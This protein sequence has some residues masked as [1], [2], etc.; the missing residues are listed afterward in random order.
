MTNVIGTIINDCADGSARTRQELRFNTLFGVRPTFLGVGSYSPI[1]AAGNLLDQLDVLTKFPLADKGR[2]NIVLVNVAPRA[3]DV[4]LKWD[5]GTPFCYFRI[6]NTLIVSTYEGHCLALARDLG[7]ISEVQ[8]LDVPTV[9]KAAVEWGGLSVEEAEKVNHSQ[10]RSL[11][12][13][14]LVAYWLWKGKPV[15]SK[16]QSLAE[17]PS[18]K[19]Q[20]WQIDNFD[21]VKTTLLPEDI[22]F[23]QSKQILLHNGE[24]ATCYRR[25]TDVPKYTT[26]LTIGSSGYG[27]RRFLEVVIGGC[28][29][30]GSQ[31]G[32]T[33]GSTVLK[34]IKVREE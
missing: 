6:D 18:S 10:F 17:L 30:A 14:P 33:I 11:E 2:E 16:K 26:A 21:N 31:H 20:V 12:F 1:E 22:K 13:L 19:G 5:N 24:V 9:T 27:T 32:F 4:K 29:K 8:L 23:K 25:L 15:P 3:E 34:N 28:G 7:I